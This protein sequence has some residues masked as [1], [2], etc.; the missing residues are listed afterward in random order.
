[1]P[2][3]HVRQLSLGL[4]VAIALPSA[5][6]AASLTPVV[7]FANAAPAVKVIII[8]LIAATLAAIV[9]AGVKLAS[10]PRLSGGSA[11]LSGLRLGGPLAGLVGG[12]YGGFTMALGLANMAEPVPV[13]IL[14]RGAAEVMLLIVLGLVSG[15]V[16]VIANWA[17]EARIDRAVLSA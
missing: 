8:C 6:S 2:A 3:T 16:A 9:V 5:A 12:A 13:S 17:V 4:A 10:G 11:F 7:V 14:A 15:S 1:M